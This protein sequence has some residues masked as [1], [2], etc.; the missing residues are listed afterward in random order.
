SAASN[1]VEMGLVPS[2]NQ[3]GGNV[4]GMATFNDRLG[5][6]RLELVKELMPNV[7]LIGY[8]LNPVDRLSEIEAKDV[9]SAA[10]ALGIDMRTFNAKSDSDLASVFTGIE[11]MRIGGLVVSGAPFFLSKRQKV[12]GLATRSAVPTIYAWREYVLAGGL[13]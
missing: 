5:T 12:V 11:E 3:P 6:K 10:R 1:P 2:L 13:I 9:N 7:R 8:L 4:T